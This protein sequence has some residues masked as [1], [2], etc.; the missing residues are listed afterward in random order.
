M[1]D[2]VKPFHGASYDWILWIDSDMSFTYEDIKQIISHEGEDEAVITGACPIDKNRIAAGRY[3]IQSGKSLPQYLS[4][5][6]VDEIPVQENGLHQVDFA[7]GAFLAVRQ[8]V[9][10]SIGFPWYKFRSH[11]E[12]GTWTSE[13]VGFTIAAGE[14]GYTTWLDPK[15]KIGHKRSLIFQP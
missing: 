12:F 2:G 15:V 11:P 14:Q 1:Y 8:G 5:K 9:Y 10:E 6:L 4:A 13:D 3:A 7:G